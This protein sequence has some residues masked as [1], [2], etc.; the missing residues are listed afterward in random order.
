MF[1]LCTRYFKDIGDDVFATE[2]INDAYHGVNYYWKCFCNE[3]KA[4]RIKD[5]VLKEKIES[6]EWYLNVKL[7]NLPYEDYQKGYAFLIEEYHSD[8]AVEEHEIQTVWSSETQIL[9]EEIYDKLHDI[10]QY[11]YENDDHDGLMLWIDEVREAEDLY[12]SFKGFVP[13][14]QDREM[15]EATSEL[16]YQILEYYVKLVN[17]SSNEERQNRKVLDAIK[18]SDMIAVRNLLYSKLQSEGGF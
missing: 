18:N 8:S 13:L 12:N 4:Q 7:I 9:I 11:C 6:K 5:Y 14:L 2:N 15:E 3:A 16:R 10:R 17:V 1:F